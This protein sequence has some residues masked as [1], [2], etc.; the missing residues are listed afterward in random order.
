MVEA[1]DPQ[2]RSFAARAA[3]SIRGR[4][5]NA[6]RRLPGYDSRN[7][8]R[9]RQID[10]FT[11]FLAEDGRRNGAVLEVSPGWNTYWK[12]ICPDYTAVDYPDF[13]ICKDKLERQ[14]PTVICDQVLEHVRRPVEASRNIHAMTAMGGWA[15]VATPFLFRVHARPYDFNRWTPAGLK[16]LLV[17]GGFAE[18][19]VSSYGWGNK[20]CARAHIG[21]PVRDY[22]LYR[23]LS[24]DDEYPLM[25]WAFAKKT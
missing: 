21:G 2:H 23:D 6:A 25:V 17:E 1:A 22:G 20:A 16:Q 24:N 8:L 3:G 14:F 5:A 15:M 4:I 19:A 11:A 13:D 10:A 7:W 18:D 12:S 9:V